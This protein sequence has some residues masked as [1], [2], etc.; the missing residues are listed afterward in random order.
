MGYINLR[1]TYLREGLGRAVEAECGEHLP[2][3]RMT[4]NRAHTSAKDA[5]PARL[6][7]KQ[8]A[9]KI[10]SVA[11]YRSDPPNRNHDLNLNNLHTNVT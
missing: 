5:G 4:F 7:V 1:L 10:P 6:L 11:A 9:G 2:L 8:S 3:F